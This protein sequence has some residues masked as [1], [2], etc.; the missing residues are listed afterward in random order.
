VVPAANLIVEFQPGTSRAGNGLQPGQGSWL[1]R[2][3][4]PTEPHVLKQTVSPDQAKAIADYLRTETHFA[5]FFCYNTNQ[6]FFQVGNFAQFIPESVS[7]YNPAGPGVNRDGDK[8]SSDGGPSGNVAV[9]LSSNTI[10]GGSAS[11]GRDGKDHRE[12]RKDH[13]DDGKEHHEVANKGHDEGEENHEKDHH[14]GT[15]SHGIALVKAH[16]S[17]LVKANPKPA[18][19]ATT[20]SEPHPASKK[21][22]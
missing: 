20:K 10:A 12:D 1:D 9:M 5:T 21:N 2:G 3:L 8:N 17:P 7:P 13:R 4:A 22:A 14:T 6:G 18:P 19:R 15:S 11:K 16:P